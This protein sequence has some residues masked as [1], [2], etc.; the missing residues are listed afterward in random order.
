MTT[1]VIHD[2]DLSADRRFWMVLM[3]ILAVIAFFL[4]SRDA[5]NN[6]GAVAYGV[7][8]EFT[9]V[10]S[11]GNSFDHHRLKGQL[12]VILINDQIISEDISLY[13][14]RFSQVTAMG[15]KYLHALVITDG[16]PGIS[17]KVVQYLSISKEDFLRL[18]TWREDQFKGDVILV[19]QNGV[20][21]GVFDLQEKAQRLLFEGAVKGIL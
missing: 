3:T 10:D 19:D 16:I 17:D 5:R 18:S 14:H 6:Y 15:R 9:S 1:T 7:F 21:R 11:S 12:S 4:L 8:P 13:L 2:R 20:I